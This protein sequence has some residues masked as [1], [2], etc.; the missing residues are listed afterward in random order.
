MRV[1]VFLWLNFTIKRA[2]YYKLG[3]PVI[4]LRCGGFF[5]G[6]KHPGLKPPAPI[7]REFEQLTD[8][9]QSDRSPAPGAAGPTDK[10]PAES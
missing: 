6:H 4:L 7:K 2:H 3:T 9:P 8:T 5:C 10:S 1:S